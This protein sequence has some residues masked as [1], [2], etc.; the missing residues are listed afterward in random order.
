KFFHEHP[1]EN[2]LMASDE[3][4]ARKLG[5]QAIRGPPRQRELR[6]LR[7]GART[8]NVWKVLTQSIEYPLAGRSAA[9]AVKRLR[10]NVRVFGNEWSI[11]C[12]LCRTTARMGEACFQ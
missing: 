11:C 1:V 4:G 9:N 3:D 10:W 7:L 12:R 8:V 5:F 2:G 6:V